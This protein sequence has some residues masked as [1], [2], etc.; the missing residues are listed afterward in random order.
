MHPLE[1][2]HLVQK[3]QVLRVR[4]ILAVRQ[5]GQ[6]EEAEN[7]HPVLY[8]D[9]ND[10]RILP[11]E[12]GAL[13]ARLCRA[14][15]FKSAAVDPYHNRLFLRVRIHRLPNVQIQA[16]LI[17]RVEGTELADVP[18]LAGAFRKVVGLIYAVIRDNIHR[19]LPA[20]VSD[21]LLS[22]KGDA[23]EG[24]DLLVRL[25]ADKGAVYAPDCQGLVILAVGD[26]VIL[27]VQCIHSLSCFL[28]IR[29][30]NTHFFNTLPIY[31]SISGR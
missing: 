10:I 2:H 19:R 3:P 5:V 8:R 7:I 11:D 26:S 17:L 23:L 4:V 25:F 29:V 20:K 28:D 27:A 24:D 16:V 21:R 18:L 1:R 22:D 6:M 31:F 14:A 13:L 9:E 30:Q 15:D 12:I